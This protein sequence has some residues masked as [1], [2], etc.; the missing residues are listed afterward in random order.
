MATKARKSVRKTHIDEGYFRAYAGS[1]KSYDRAWKDHTYSTECIWQFQAPGAPKLKSVCVLGAATGRILKEFDRKLGVKPSGCEVSPWAHA[2]IPQPY[3]RRVRLQDMRD[4]AADLVRKRKRFTLMYSNSFVYLPE[5]EILP[6]L[7]KL[8]KC[9]EIL[10]FRSS[11]AGS[12]CPDPYRKTLKSYAWWNQKLQKAG[13]QELKTV[14]GY[15]TYLWI[16]PA[17]KPRPGV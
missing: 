9:C 6:L 5:R 14:R 3:R 8:A 13:F 1:G 16:A 15:R 2:R 7:K 17:S 12:A 4:Y 11:F 10:H